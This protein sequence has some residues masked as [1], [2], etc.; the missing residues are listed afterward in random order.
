M[1]KDS[2]NS[3]PQ[4]LFTLSRK[5]N[6]IEAVSSYSR[7]MIDPIIWPQ[8]VFLLRSGFSLTG[9]IMWVSSKDPDVHLKMIITRDEEE[10]AK[11]F[12]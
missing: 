8:S 2:V 5:E 12:W 7:P 11:V 9:T 3:I 4:H 10:I 6:Q 1:K